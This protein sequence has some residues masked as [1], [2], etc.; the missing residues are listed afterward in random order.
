MK[1]LLPNY[2]YKEPFDKADCE[3]CVHN[4]GKEIVACS[5]ENAIRFIMYNLKC[6][7]KDDE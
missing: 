1:V 6:G 2:E 4:K 3:D 7:E 5:N